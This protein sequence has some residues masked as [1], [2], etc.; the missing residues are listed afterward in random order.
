M[1][2]NVK[3]GEIQGEVEK[4]EIGGGKG[5]GRVGVWRRKK[6]KESVLY[7]EGSSPTVCHSQ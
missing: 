4:K 5:S 1:E 2:I 6:R 3:G 7:M